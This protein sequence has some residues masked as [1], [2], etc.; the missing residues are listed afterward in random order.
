ML[1]GCTN[2]KFKISD[3]VNV[4]AEEGG[5]EEEVARPF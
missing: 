4:N 5:E 1:C 3:P 2:W